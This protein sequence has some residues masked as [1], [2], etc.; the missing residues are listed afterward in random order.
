MIQTIEGIDQ[1]S[2]LETF[3]VKRNR[4]GLNGLSDVINLLTCPSISCLDISENKIE[5]EGIL[6]EVFVKM[7]S[8][9]VLY[10]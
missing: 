3:N 4:I 8:L 2:K 9:A 5:D 10:F 1:L 6:E 7:P